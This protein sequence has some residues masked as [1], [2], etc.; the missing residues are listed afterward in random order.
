MILVTILLW[1]LFRL[2]DFGEVAD[3]AKQLS[4]LTK[5]DGTTM[6]YGG[7]ACL[8]LYLIEAPITK[9]LMLGNENSQCNVICEV[10]VLSIMLAIMVLCPLHFTFNFFY[11]RF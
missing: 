3:F 6:V 5:I 11:L 9:R 7:G 4:S 10:S 1:Q 8:L 2:T